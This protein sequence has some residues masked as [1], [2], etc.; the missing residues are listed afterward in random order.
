M[1]INPRPPSVSKRE[2]ERQREGSVT[3]HLFGVH[4]SLHSGRAVDKAKEG[5]PVWLHSNT[6]CSLYIT[7]CTVAQ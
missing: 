1:L 6:H 2:R 5:T 7:H 4:V 3:G